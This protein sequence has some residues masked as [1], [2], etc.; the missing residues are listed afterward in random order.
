MNNTNHT[1]KYCARRI[2]REVARIAFEL[3]NPVCDDPV[4]AEIFMKR[5]HAGNLR[6]EPKGFSIPGITNKRVAFVHASSGDF[7]MARWKNS[8]G[9][10]IDCSDFEITNTFALRVMEAVQLDIPSDCI[11]FTQLDEL[12]DRW[13]M[14]FEES[15]IKRI[16]SDRHPTWIKEPLSKVL[17]EWRNKNPALFVRVAPRARIETEIPLLVRYDPQRALAEYKDKL[18]RDQFLW[19]LSKRPDAAIR[20]AFERIP[21]AD[22]IDLV[23]AYST[24]ALN[25]HLDRMSE[26]ELEVASSADAMTAFKL[27]HFLEDRRHAIVLSESYPA[28]FFIDLI[29]NEFDLT[30]EIIN[31][32]IEYPRIWYRSHYQSFEILF[33]SLKST[34]WI[35]FSGEDI[36]KLAEKLGPK[37]R[38]EIQIYIGSKI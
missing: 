9:T 10:V 24:L 14:H 3:E 34:F 33:R 21:R 20:H 38:K 8:S 5:S 37:L 26:N 17:D 1:L 13:L 30:Q 22:R 6:I 35:N 32:V 2:S 28:F 16:F 11:S 23:R 15:T 19:C 12:N 36:L 18:D 27:R 4:T 25:Y 29:E 7:I 31:S